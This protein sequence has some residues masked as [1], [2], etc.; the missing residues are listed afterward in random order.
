MSYD[1]DAYAES[2]EV[3]LNRAISFAGQDP[4][5][6]TE[7]KARSLIDVAEGRLGDLAKAT[8]LDVGCGTG[9][10]HR[11]LAPRF[12]KLHAV[13]VSAGLLDIARSANDDVAYQ[14][15]D[16][17]ELPFE[18]NAFD[19]AF[20]ICV[21]HHVPPN[22]WERFIAEMARVVRPGGLVAV[23]EHNPVNPLTRLVTIRC[24]FDEGIALV[25]RRRLEQLMH[26]AGMNGTASRYILFS[27]WRGAAVE[28]AE[29]RLERLPLGAQYISY[30]NA[31]Q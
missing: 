8:A 21:V 29:R 6:F 30:A 24:A 11:S 7:A 19:L 1:F 14:L 17:L 18:S 5:V 2:Y 9:N 22:Q 20:A 28:W 15:Y 25:P 10:I 4:S 26:R 16:G 27:P 23:V 13:D 3:E 31:S 12:S